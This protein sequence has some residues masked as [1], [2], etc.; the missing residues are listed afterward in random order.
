MPS[1]VSL[2]LRPASVMPDND[3]AVPLVST[4][5]AEAA[6]RWPVAGGRA[7]VLSISFE[8]AQLCW[9][10]KNHAVLAFACRE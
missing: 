7:Q 3:A 4:V 9:L 1:R 5:K 6:G 10:G 8:V 2:A